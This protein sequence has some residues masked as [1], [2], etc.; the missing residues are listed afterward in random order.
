ML[1]F[2]L[3]RI[4]PRERLIKLDL[5]PMNFADD[6]VAALG[7]HHGCC[8]ARA[9]ISPSEGA[10]LAALI[11][12]YTRAIDMA[13]VVKRLDALEAEAEWW[14]RQHEYRPECAKSC[15]WN[16]VR[17]PISRRSGGNKRHGWQ[18]FVRVPLSLWLISLF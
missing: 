9:R 14:R 10:S 8:G 5:P 18:A 6:A 15:V 2:L 12:T 3:G 17:C 13:D 4:L 16:D 7:C 11:D 1:K